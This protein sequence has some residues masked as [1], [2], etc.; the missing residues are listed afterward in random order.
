MAINDILIIDPRKDT[1]WSKLAEETL[2]DEVFPKASYETTYDWGKAYER[3][4]ESIKPDLYF[5]TSTVTA[6]GTAEAIERLKDKHPDATVALYSAGRWK[7]E[8]ALEGL[9]VLLLDKADPKWTDKVREQ[10][11]EL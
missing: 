1:R 5:I 6:E 4:E 7:L 9:D 8:Q 3:A 10:Y 2:R 11:V